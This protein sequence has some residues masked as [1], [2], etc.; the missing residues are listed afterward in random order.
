M[1]STW[2]PARWHELSGLISSPLHAERKA[3]DLARGEWVLEDVCLGYQLPVPPLPGFD[4]NSILAQADARTRQLMWPLPWRDQFAEYGPGFVRLDSQS[5]QHFLTGMLNASVSNWPMRSCEWHDATAIVTELTMDNLFHALIHAVPTLELYRKLLPT[6]R[7]GTVHFVPHFTQYWPREVNATRCAF[8]RSVGWQVLVRSLLG[9]VDEPE[10]QAV[11]ARAGALTELGK[12]NCYRRMYGGHTAFMP[13][14]YMEG[15]AVHR[16]V[17]AFGDALAIS[18]AVA[19]GAI[20]QRRIIF[21]LRRSGTRQLVNEEALRAAVA[22]NAIL[23]GV[24][25]FSVFESLPIREQHALVSMSTALAGV[26][27][28]GL[29]WTML[30]PHSAVGQSSCLEITGEWAKFGR[31]DYYSLSQ[32]NNVHYIRLAQPNWPGCLQ[33]HRPNYRSCGN[34]TANIADF[35]QVLTYMVRRFDQ[36]DRGGG[37]VRHPSKVELKFLG[38]IPRCQTMEKAIARSSHISG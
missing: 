10:W 35:V 17:A 14:P 30:L 34:I 38:G 2:S 25:Q 19:R 3:S 13:P 31:S 37:C 15:E 22:G 33:V 9:Q 11:A 28:M 36:R 8:N 1:R 20:V 18:S 4:R 7:G 6:L 29:A 12:C 21:Q 32:A 23:A 16:R 5:K 24:V 26:H 27:G